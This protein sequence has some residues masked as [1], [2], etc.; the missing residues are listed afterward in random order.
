[1]K[2]LCNSIKWK[3][4]FGLLLKAALCR[5]YKLVVAHHVTTLI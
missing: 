2:C 4:Q 3:K 5:R 1:M